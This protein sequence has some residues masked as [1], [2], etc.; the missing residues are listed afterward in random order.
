[1]PET[2]WHERVAS[3]CKGWNLQGKE[4]A[5]KEDKVESESKENCKEWKLQGKEFA[6]QG[7]HFANKDYIFYHTVNVC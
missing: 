1:M 7:N 5:R 6:L 2:D 4:N 3:P